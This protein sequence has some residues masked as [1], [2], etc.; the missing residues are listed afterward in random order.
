MLAK[1]EPDMVNPEELRAL[2]YG[3]TVSATEALEAGLNVHAFGPAAQV[4]E[5]NV[6]A[7]AVVEAAP[8]VIF[9]SWSV[10]DIV[11]FVPVPHAPDAILGVF[12]VD[13][14]ECPVDVIVVV[15]ARPF[16][17]VVSPVV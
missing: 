3:S 15:T 8:I 6:T 7:H 5:P 4:E 2:T 1:T 12:P 13:G 10:P 9:P 16:D 11:P 14:V 17:K